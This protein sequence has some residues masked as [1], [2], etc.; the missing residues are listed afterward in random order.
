MS[1]SS[2]GLNINYSIYKSSTSSFRSNPLC[3]IIY[4]PLSH[5]V[6]TQSSSKNIDW[7]LSTYLT[8]LN[9]AAWDIINVSKNL[10]SKTS[11]SS[12][13]KKA[14]EATDHDAVVGTATS[15]A[16]IVTHTSNIS[17]LATLPI[18]LGTDLIS[19]LK[20]SVDLGINV[21]H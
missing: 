8:S 5:K 6:Y 11:E 12:F 18:I 14:V 7:M 13:D 15:E 20:T 10:S 1:V 3:N 4:E 21:F 9:I 17:N 2:L 16:N 19:A